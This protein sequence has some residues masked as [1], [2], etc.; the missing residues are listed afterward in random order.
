[1]VSETQTSAVPGRRMTD[2]LVL[3]RE[4]FLS[5]TRRRWKGILV[6]IDQSKAFDRIDRNYLWETLRAKGIP[7]AFIDALKYLYGRAKVVPMINRWPGDKV[8][9]SSGIRT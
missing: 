4:V 5:V 3:M 2:S 7:A 9:I 6:Q 1:M 8:S